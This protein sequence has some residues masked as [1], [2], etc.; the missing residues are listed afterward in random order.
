VSKKALL[1]IFALFVVGGS[2]FYFNKKSTNSCAIPKEVQ[3]IKKIPVAEAREKL[4]KIYEGISG[5]GISDKEVKFI[6][7]AGG[8]A[9]YGEIKF[10]SAQK[11]LDYLKP[12]KDDVFYDLGS[13]VGKLVLQAY[14][15]TDI[16]KSVGIELSGTRYELAV[17]AL[18]AAAENN[19]FDHREAKFLNENIITADFSDATIVFIC[20]TCY[21]EELMEKIA[22]KLI[23]LKPGT[24]IAS[25]KEFKAGRLKKIET[26]K[27]PMTW[28]EGSSVYIY[29]VEEEAQKAKA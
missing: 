19:L 3:L 13:G 25:L 4:D 11:L 27:L 29:I 23:K 28:S 1:V 10:E 16:K 6:K 22:E 5:F 20:S 24:K 26:L 2:I 17:K 15:T 21:S 7:K 12:T 8:A 18:K 14:L 9:T